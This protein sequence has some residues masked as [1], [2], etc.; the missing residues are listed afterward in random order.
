MNTFMAYGLPHLRPYVRPELVELDEA[1]L[2]IA[3]ARMQWGPFW[4]FAGFVGHEASLT[5]LLFSNQ[6]GLYRPARTR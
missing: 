3:L 5:R 1:S 4:P 6:Q 2:R